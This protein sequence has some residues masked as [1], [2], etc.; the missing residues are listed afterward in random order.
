MI[1]I[2]KTYRDSVPAW[3]RDASPGEGAP[4]IVFIVLDDVGYSDLGCYGSEIRT[5]NI[6]TLAGCGLRY[7]NFHV[8]SMCSPTRACLLT[9]RNA[10]SVGVGIIAEFANGYPAYEGRI[11]R[12]AA[13]LPE[14]LRDHGYHTAAVGKWHLTN[15]S[16]YR[17]SGP[18]DDWPLGRGFNRWY[19]FHGALA[20]HFH[21][22]LYRDNHAIDV[23]P[24]P[25]YH[26]SG[27]L[28]DQGI[29][30]VRDHLAS[31][32]KRPYFLYLAFGACH[33]PHQVPAE[34][35]E[36][37]RGRYGIGWDAIREARLARQKASG[38]VPG[39]TRL[40]PRNPGVVA[41]EELPPDVKRLSARLQEAYA[42]FV[43]H[44]DEQIGRFLDYLRAIGRFDNT[45]IVLLSDNGASNEGGAI[46]AF[47]GRKNGTY[48]P[49]T[50]EVGLSQLDK[51]G[52]GLAFNHY[53]AGWAQASNTPLKWYKKNT[54]GGGIRAP[55]VVNWPRRIADR[56]GLR[57]QY[58]HVIDVTPTILELLG[59]QAPATYSGVEQLPMHGTSM[60]YTFHAPQ[61]QTRKETQYFEL[62]GDRAIWHKGWKA[63]ARHLAGQ[64][65]E[66][67]RWELYHLDQD[68]S[69]CDE[70]SG[71]H[72]G[73]LEEMARLW[74]AEAER[75][76]VLP[77][78]DRGW[79]RAA[80]RMKMEFISRY[81]LYP[82]A[83]RLDR[84]ICP[85]ITDR[86][87][88]ITAEVQLAAGNEGVL[89]AWGSYF[90]GLVLYVKED[91]LVYEYV[92]SETER[93]VLRSPERLEPGA[94]KLSVD[95][96]RTGKN[97]GT[98]TMQ[99]DGMAVADTGIPA[100]W[101]THGTTAG[102]YCGRD[103]GAP[104]SLDYPAPFAFTGEIKKVVI[105]LQTDG[106]ADLGE[107]FKAILQEQ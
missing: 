42:A 75:Y 64:D 35:I 34:H 91:H 104:V 7:S 106:E 28:V 67:D 72:P 29:G 60:A 70:L 82:N 58:H 73:K 51:I 17:A 65:H 33:W 8:T 101:P 2:G 47:N 98:A 56:G 61:A 20:D 46:G 102:L 18:F 41:W 23:N 92:Y 4:D 59:I 52:S 89:L 100:T 83:S 19:G 77:L 81:E 69:E 10:H 74:W 39:E 94:A 71:Q 40:P 93:H 99:V 76:G 78:D 9:G 62:L 97:R 1:R 80:E 85:D 26:L 96:R 88:R 105:E 22:E 66:S 84:L 50:P 45:L 55:L 48:G 49:E 31:A 86:S 107:Q 3:G 57:K 15:V 87:Y 103:L 16:H 79:E 32:T 53:P 90:G 11:T 27:D 54:Y 63:V 36:R 43:E 44:T 37:V 21:P 25:G 24:G 5:P 30:M 14:I 12:A 68:F 38:V 13:T 6:D 95:F